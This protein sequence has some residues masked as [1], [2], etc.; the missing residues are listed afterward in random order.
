MGREPISWRETPPVLALWALLGLLA[1]AAVW[2]IVCA[3]RTLW[4]LL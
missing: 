1:W 2:G 4:G 3:S